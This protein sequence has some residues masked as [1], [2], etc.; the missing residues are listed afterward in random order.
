MIYRTVEIL[1][2]RYAGFILCLIVILNLAAGSLVMNMNPEIYPP[3]FPFD[4]TFFFQPTLAVHWWLY[5]LLVTFGLFAINMTACFIESIVRLKTATTGRLRLFIGIFI[6]AALLL[7][8]AAHIHDG[9]YGDSGQATLSP[10]PTPL[11]G[12]GDVSALSVHS[13]YHPDGS[14]RDTE[15]ILKIT[16]ADGHSVGKR[17]AYNEPATFDGGQRE[18]IIQGGEERPAGVI[19]IRKNDGETF[20]MMPYQPQQMSGGR[21]TLRDIYPSGMRV[22]IAQFVWE[23]VAE[24]PQLLTMALHHDMVRHN[25]ITIA[26][27]VLGYKEMLEVPVVAVMT[28]Y[29]PAIP[30]ILLSLLLASIG[31]VLQIYFARRQSEI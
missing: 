8:M 27:E 12:I 3:F 15:A 6:H 30:I 23:R 31:T 24:D 17:I 13:T 10:E 5:L 25:K 21:L 29:N 16:Q 20:E 1:G 22:L 7:T 11:A 2:N 18:I 4:L 26:G 19:L 14:L 9:F 28:R